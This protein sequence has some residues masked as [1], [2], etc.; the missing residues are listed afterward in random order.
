M[1]SKW[2]TMPV[3]TLTVFSARLLTRAP[4]AST[5]AAVPSDS[6]TS[7]KGM[8]SNEVLSKFVKLSVES[9]LDWGNCNI[10]CAWEFSEGEVIEVVDPKL[11]PEC[12]TIA[13][14]RLNPRTQLFRPSVPMVARSLTLASLRR[15]PLWLSWEGR[16]GTLM[17]FTLA[18]LRRRLLA[19]RRELR[20][21]ASGGFSGVWV[22]PPSWLDCNS[23]SDPFIVNTCRLLYLLITTFAA[24]CSILDSFIRHAMLPTRSSFNSAN[25]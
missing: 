4:S 14:L 12:R 7:F 19:E 17:S 18:S 21:E 3:D 16:Q 6:L 11:S 25:E 5:E 1:F 8:D 2:S 24:K 15:K 10:V 9:K 22:F 13:L 20:C 23:V